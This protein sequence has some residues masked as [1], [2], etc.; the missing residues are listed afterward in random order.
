MKTHTLRKHKI[1]ARLRIL[2]FTKPAFERLMEADDLATCLVIT[3]LTHDIHQ[4]H[5]VDA[6]IESDQRDLLLEKSQKSQAENPVFE[7]QIYR[8][9]RLFIDGVMDQPSIDFEAILDVSD[10][11]IKMLRREQAQIQSAKAD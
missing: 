2:T 10:A 4:R 9:H 6:V 11:F 8:M 7:G 1:D 3:K 5:G